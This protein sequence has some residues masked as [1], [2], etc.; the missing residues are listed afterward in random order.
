MSLLDVETTAEALQEDEE[1]IEAVETFVGDAAET[2]TTEIM[3]NIETMWRTT[4]EWLEWLFPLW[5]AFRDDRVKFWEEVYKL[6]ISAF[7]LVVSFFL[8]AP[9]NS[10]NT[11][12]MMNQRRRRTLLESTRHSFRQTP[13]YLRGHSA[14][15]SAAKFKSTTIQ[16][17]HSA[18]T[19]SELQLHQQ[20]RLP[21][22]PSSALGSVNRRH[23]SICSGRVIV[24]EEEET[25]VQRFEKNF[26][27]INMSRYRRLVLPPQCKRVDK[28][29]RAA[30]PKKATT[31]TT[32]KSTS[33]SGS[34]KR[35]KRRKKR[36]RDSDEDHP[37]RR[38]RI[39][40]NNV[41]AL[42]RSFM[43]YDYMGA[44]MALIRWIVLVLRIRQIR[45]KK[46]ADLMVE[47][48]D[49]DDDESKTSVSVTGTSSAQNNNAPVTQQQ[50][51]PAAA[52]KQRQ[53]E[54]WE[55]SL[56]NPQTPDQ[57]ENDQQQ[58]QKQ[59]QHDFICDE[60]QSPIHTVGSDGHK[61]FPQLANVG[62]NMPQSSPP[63]LTIDAD[64]CSNDNPKQRK[65][66][67][68]LM[69]V[70]T[71][72]QAS[73]ELQVT[74]EPDEEKPSSQ[75]QP[76]SV[77]T[78]KTNASSLKLSIGGKKK[79]LLQNYRPSLLGGS[80]PRNSMSLTTSMTS[81]SS[82][83]SVSTLGSNATT[84]NAQVHSNS[85]GDL[86]TLHRNHNDEN[87]NW[88]N[89]NSTPEGV[90]PKVDSR[91]D[92]NGSLE[93]SSSEDAHDPRGRIQRFESD[94]SGFFFE[95]ANT[96]ASLQRMC[97]NVPLPDK[98]GY[99]VGDEF[100][101]ESSCTPLLVFVNSRSGPQQGHL[102][103]TQLRRLLNPIQVWD[104]GEDGG[105]ETVLES[106][107]GAFRNL[108]ILVCGGDGTVSWIIAALERLNLKHKW[109][110]IAILPLGTGNDLARIHGWGGGYNNESLIGIL[111]DVADSYISLL[112]QWELSIE[113]RKGKV[114]EVKSFFNYL[115]VGAD[116]QAALQV[117]MVRPLAFSMQHGRR[118]CPHYQ[119]VSSCRS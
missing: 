65:T 20:Q 105:P 57:G 31:S 41:L 29:K 76:L 110:P 17:K 58:Q 104:L 32:I 15:S 55:Q 33:S 18:S 43:T 61:E 8:L 117:H 84:S 66:E 19:D 1:L 14:M 94:L 86:T 108:R 2:I 114:K 34:A 49:D 52:E 51:P 107:S 22:T 69:A 7:I 90:T 72:V 102:L 73:S 109:P 106:F 4:I 48:D 63:P 28:P 97:I 42:V 83:S 80:A 71:P 115:G 91:E 93:D 112:D 50:S 87:S 9:S 13:N 39:Y 23:T 116:A 81:Q 113:N 79:D 54:N 98:H 92:E 119:S 68:G 101:S 5:V 60:A 53:Q 21:T 45:I 11:T 82:V 47:E 118:V 26:Q 74:G 67:S 37:A 36:D 77:T 27:T 75:R 88:E 35:K 111:E 38:L 89:M 30:A 70:S 46:T 56:W 95:T 12:M 3:T 96:Q 25:D 44:G 100:L 59:P 16:I 24:G 6:A 85:S 10:R 64:K 99:I 40:A 78:T 62:R 103:I